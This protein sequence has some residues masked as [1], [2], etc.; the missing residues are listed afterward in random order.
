[1]KKTGYLLIRSLNNSNL[2]KVQIESKAR[3]ILNTR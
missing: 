1:M 3:E 2:K